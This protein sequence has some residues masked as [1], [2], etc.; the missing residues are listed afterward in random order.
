MY[1]DPKPVFNPGAPRKSIKIAKTRTT[2]PL[3]WEL[4]LQEKQADLYNQLRAIKTA[5]KNREIQKLTEEITNICYQRDRLVKEIDELI[6]QEENLDICKSEDWCI[7]TK[8]VNGTWKL[9]EIQTLHSELTE[10]MIQIHT[11]LP[12]TANRLFTGQ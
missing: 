1:L 2:L 12:S 11:A 8:F 10:M 4:Q 9:I 7:L 5:N 3:L 6:K